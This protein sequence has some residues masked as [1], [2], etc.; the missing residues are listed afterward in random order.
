MDFLLIDLDFAD[1]RSFKLLEKLHSDESYSSLYILTTSFTTSQKFIKEL[2]KYNIIGFISKPIT[3]EII[4]TKID[5]IMNK[6]KDHFSKRK[7]VRV[8]PADNELMRL[9]IKLK[10]NKHL[11]AKVLDVS[12]GGIAALLYTKCDDKELD[13]G[14]LIEHIVFEASNKEID[15]DAVVV[16]KKENFIAFKFSHFYNNTN[17]DL[18]RYI[19]KKLSV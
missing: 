7:H 15:V 13:P 3:K 5:L 8:K 11:S 6:F 18:T 12:L 10:N 9:S 14:K 19:M 2:Q 16:N 17:K 1:K 4:E